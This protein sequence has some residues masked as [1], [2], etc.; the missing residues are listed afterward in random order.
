ML[1][2]QNEDRGGEGS[3]KHRDAPLKRPRPVV[4]DTTSHIF[5]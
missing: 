3:W 1:Q 2:R 5:T 4:Y